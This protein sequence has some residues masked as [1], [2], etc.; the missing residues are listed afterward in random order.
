MHVA[1]GR[2]LVQQCARAGALC[3]QESAPLVALAGMGKAQAHEDLNLEIVVSVLRGKI[4]GAQILIAQMAANG[5]NRTQR[6]FAVRLRF[7]QCAGFEFDLRESS[8]GANLGIGVVRGNGR[9]AALLIVAACQRK[10]M[11]L[12]RGVTEKAKSLGHAVGFVDFAREFERLFEILSCLFT[13][14]LLQETFADASEQEGSRAI[15]RT[16]LR[17]LQAAGVIRAGSCR[18]IA[19]EQ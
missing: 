18:L 15:D 16:L 2:H 12:P 3:N 7:L 9:L 1:A 19:F 5:L 17:Q 13:R 14:T 11:L 8:L 10:V 4:T 6:A